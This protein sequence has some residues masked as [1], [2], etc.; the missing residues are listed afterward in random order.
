[1]YPGAG[2]VLKVERRTNPCPDASIR[3]KERPWKCTHV[4]TFLWIPL[5]HDSAVIDH[6]WYDNDLMHCWVTSCSA[7]VVK[8]AEA[9]QMG[10]FEVVFAEKSAALRLV[11]PATYLAPPQIYKMAC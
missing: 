4:Y 8:C 7:P 2:L 3:Y 9:S 10:P 11:S 6:M 1:M 5:S